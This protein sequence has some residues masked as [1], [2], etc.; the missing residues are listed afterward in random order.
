[1]VYDC[2]TFFNE[3]D[4]L[5]IRLNELDPVVDYFVLVEANYTHQ[6]KDKPY[7]FEA[8]KSRFADFLYKIIYIKLSD[9]P[10]VAGK[11]GSE[12]SWTL[13]NYQRN[14]ILRGLT[15][16]SDNDCILISDVDE[17]PA[18]ASVKENADSEKVLVFWQRFYY[19]FLNC[20]RMQDKGKW[21][22]KL[23]KF[24]PFMSG[25]VL[26]SCKADHI[27]YWPG[28]IM[29]PYYKIG[30]VQ[31]CR[32]RREDQDFADKHL[33]DAG[34]HFSFMGGTDKIIEKLNAFAHVELNQEDMKDE[35]YIKRLIESGQCLHSNKVRLRF[36]DI[37]DSY[38]Q[39]LSDNRHK[40]RHLIYK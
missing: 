30:S 4:L 20:I 17:I 31:Q 39:Y 40:F 22:R 27:K 29:I 26:P 19:Y 11:Q 35:A 13:E 37:D 7:I 32:D 6:G 21:S 14:A 10:D 2:F 16:C 15:H 28:S 5:E 9:C 25:S 3:L 38:P 18:S 33:Y 1:M 8:N 23:E 34:W 36:I 12:L 24:M